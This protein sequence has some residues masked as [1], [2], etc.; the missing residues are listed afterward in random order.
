MKQNVA[1]PEWRDENE[2]AVFTHGLQFEKIRYTVY[3]SG[4]C[5]QRDNRCLKPY[6]ATRKILKWIKQ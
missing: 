3:V 4:D 2:V 1:D 6:F 5:M